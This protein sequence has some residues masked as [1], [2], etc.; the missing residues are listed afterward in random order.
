MIDSSRRMGHNTIAGTSIV[1]IDAAGYAKTDGAHNSRARESAYSGH[2]GESVLDNQIKRVRQHFYV[3]DNQNQRH[4]NIGDS[5]F[6][7]HPL[8]FGRNAPEPSG[9]GPT[10]DDDHEQESQAVIHFKGFQ[11]G[12]CGGLA[13][14]QASPWPQN[15]ATGGEKQGAFFPPHGVFHDK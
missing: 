1:G 6:G 2:R 15:E 8:D 11:H 14:H 12:T 3:D 10:D 9:N 5:Q 13:L 7:H 4:R